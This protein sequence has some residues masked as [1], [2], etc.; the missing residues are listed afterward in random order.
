[1]CMHVSMYICVCMCTCKG[2]CMLK[3]AH[4]FYVRVCVDACI[5]AHTCISKVPDL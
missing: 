5:H 2:G 4:I 3:S 1:M